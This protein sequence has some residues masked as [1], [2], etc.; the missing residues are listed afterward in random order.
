MTLHMTL[1]RPCAECPFRT[2]I[3]PYLTTA[4]AQE[5]VGC[6]D[7]GTFPCHK[8]L[9]YREDEDGECYGHNTD[10]TQH[11]AG[12]LILLEHEERPSQLMRI[13]E[14]LGG[15][16][17]RKLDMAAPVFTSREDFIDAQDVRPKKRRRRR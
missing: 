14:R 9:D 17:R 13:Y 11:C 1:N 8:T 2:D 5:I 4:R 12:A 16:D 7:R 3:P 15:Y 6:L 10:K